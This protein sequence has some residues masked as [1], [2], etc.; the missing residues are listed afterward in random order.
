MA[1]TGENFVISGDFLP[2]I[3]YFHSILPGEYPILNLARV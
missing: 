3:Q 1:K 2:Q